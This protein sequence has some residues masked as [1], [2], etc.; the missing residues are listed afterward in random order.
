MSM[1]SSGGGGGSGADLSQMMTAAALNKQNAQA[2]S[3]MPSLVD[4]GSGGMTNFLTSG[5]GDEDKKKKKMP[6]EDSYDAGDGS[7][8]ASY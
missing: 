5:Q 1:P 8:G 7:S 2:G 3:E 4:Y 6:W